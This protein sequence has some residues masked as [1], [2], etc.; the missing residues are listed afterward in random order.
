M[1]LKYGKDIFEKRSRELMNRSP[2]VIDSGK[3]MEEVFEILTQKRKRTD[4]I[5]VIE[6][7]KLAG[8][9]DLHIGR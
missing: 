6:S 7:G 2:F 9:V 5:P 4:F 8:A 3:T 1:I